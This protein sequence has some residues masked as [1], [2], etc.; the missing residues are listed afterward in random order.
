VSAAS[1]TNVGNGWWRFSASVSSAT[2]A[3][4]PSV[5][6][7]LGSAD[8]T[9]SY[10]G[11]GYSGVFLWG[12]QLEAGAFPTSYVATVAS[13]VTRAADAAS[14]TGANF[15]SWYNQAEGTL[16]ADYSIPFDSSASVFPLV[17]SFDNGSAN[18]RTVIAQRT[19]DDKIQGAIFVNNVLQASILSTANATYG[20]PLRAALSY[21]TNDVA[22]TLNADAV[23]TDTSALIGTDMSAMRIGNAATPG[24]N[25]AL[26]GTIR[27]L[28]Y[29]PLRISNTNLVALTS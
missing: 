22:F 28:S 7:S 26:S 20:P 4:T 25:N 17:A 12:A 21:K 23:Q 11:N 27:K 1:A 9:A 15:S 13:Q 19:I 2:G 29:Y 6:I 3:T 14:M 10:T 8:N 16:Y 5:R 18:N 24:Y